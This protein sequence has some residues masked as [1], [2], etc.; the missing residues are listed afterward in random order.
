[1][2][3]L[4]IQMS[5]YYKG[6]LDIPKYIFLLKN[7]QCKAARA[8]LPVTDQTLTVLASTVLLAPTPSL[9]N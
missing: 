8:H 2:V 4:T 7:A 6:T 5:K 9:H 3:L 1:M